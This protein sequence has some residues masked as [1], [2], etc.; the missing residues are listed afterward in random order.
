MKTRVV[1]K[2]IN[3]LMQWLDNSQNPEEISLNQETRDLFA[4][5]RA[6]KSDAEKVAKE[7]LEAFKKTEIKEVKSSFLRA[8]REKWL[9]E[10]GPGLN[11]RY[12]DAIKIISSI[13][14]PLFEDKRYH[15][16]ELLLIEE[17]SYDSTNA[18][19]EWRAYFEHR[20]RDALKRYCKANLSEHWLSLNV[21]LYSF[22]SNETFPVYRTHIGVPDYFHPT[23]TTKSSTKTR[24]EEFKNLSHFQKKYSSLWE[25]VKNNVSSIF[26]FDKVDKEKDYML[27]YEIDPDAL[28]GKGKVDASFVGVFTADY[29]H[30]KKNTGSPA[31]TTR[32]LIEEGLKSEQYSTN[33][34]KIFRVERQKKENLEEKNYQ[35]GIIRFFIRVGIF[36]PIKAAVPT[37][38]GSPDFINILEISYNGWVDKMK[39][40]LGDVNNGDS[41][42]YDDF[43]QITLS[44]F[45]T[46]K[47]K[48]RKP[49]KS[50]SGEWQNFEHS[51]KYNDQED[52][53]LNLVIELLDCYYPEAID[54]RVSLFEAGFFTLTQNDNTISHVYWMPIIINWRERWTGGAAYFNSDKRIGFDWLGKKDEMGYYENGSNMDFERITPDDEVPQVLITTFYFLSGLFADK[55]I[56]S[57]EESL[58]P[59]IERAAAVSIMSRNISHNIGSHVL[60]YQKH[61]FENEINMLRGGVLHDLVFE[62]DGV[63][64]MNEKKFNAQEYNELFLTATQTDVAGSLL[65]LP[66][67]RSVG[68]LL[69]YFQERQD[70]I[71][72]FASDRH[73]YFT[74]VYFHRNIMMNFCGVTLEGV[75]NIALDHIIFSEGYGKDDIIINSYWREGAVETI[76]SD[77]M[78]YEVSLPSG[79]T[80]R[81][82]IY[83]II[84]NFIRNSAKH[85]KKKAEREGGK[86]NIKIT[87]SSFDKDFFQLEMLDNSG[88]TTD[89]VIKEISGVLE[90]PLVKSDGTLDERHKGIKEI[91]IAAAWLRGIQPHQIMDK[92]I[93]GDNKIVKATKEG[94]DLQYTLFLCKPKDGLLLV[95]DQSE[96]YNQEGELVEPYRTTLKN[97]DIEELPEDLSVLNKQKKPYHFVVIHA[98]LNPD[99]ERVRKIKERCPVRVL[100]EVSDATLQSKSLK[101][102]LFEMWIKHTNVKGFIPFSLVL[103]ANKSIEDLKIGIEDLR[104]VLSVKNVKVCGFTEEIARKCPILFREHNDLKE[105]FDDFRNKSKIDKFIYV[106][107]ISG[108]NTTGRLLRNEIKDTYWYYKMLETA[109]TKVIIVDERIWRNNLGETHDEKER[110]YTRWAKKNIHIFSLENDEEYPDQLILKDLMD[111][112]VATLDN[113]GN[114]KFTT[115]RNK[116]KYHNS[117]FISLH[118]GLME[119]AVKHCA[120][121][122]LLKNNS[123]NK[124]VEILFNKF[125]RGI[126]HAKFRVM[127]HSGRSKAHIMP[128]NTAFVQ[129]SSLSSALED[130]KYTLCDLF[131]ATI[132]ENDEKTN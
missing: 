132:K 129:L 34:S 36:N 110:N 52:Q 3:Y 12:D 29:T 45:N 76:L 111:T 26:Y 101:E 39:H 104:N 109:L 14:E 40:Q 67:L 2:H 7:Y 62:T 27:V 77:E 107:G 60:S 98:N 119:R 49:I 105:K 38:S 65:K 10:E 4:K 85:G 86:L 103:D 17:D 117:H 69:G 23:D 79:N 123:E 118:Q 122:E 89:D 63:F 8:L 108:G 72:T 20:F 95:K 82:G 46:S 50:E 37:D 66:Y 81:Q 54:I 42:E 30:R 53:D 6:R 44:Q 126:F 58:R 15:Q 64:R 93:L 128:P 87:L 96:Y 28:P 33:P 125:R 97:W 9:E 124:Q 116:L 31:E 88:K 25:L 32:S 114:A 99:N 18:R 113:E 92:E 73:L 71:S 100:S 13:F 120:D 35:F 55:L 131:Y 16:Q 21:S 59:S 56:G 11:L 130:S 112:T 70:Y 43:E 22:L 68:N 106:E 94:D 19:A 74:S 127:I 102:D 121:S 1:D 57:I 83:T 5:V 80:G 24:E 61:I 84:E 75:R 51:D 91:Q 47:N 90:S 41:F 48:N 78:D 115:G